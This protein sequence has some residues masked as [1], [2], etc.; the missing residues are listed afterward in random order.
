[1]CVGQ[2]RMGRRTKLSKNF[3]YS[4]ILRKETSVIFF[5]RFSE[6]LN[7][8]LI[9]Y[10]GTAEAQRIM[11]LLGEGTIKITSPETF[12]YSSDN[13]GDN[14]LELYNTCESVEDFYYKSLMVLK[15]RAELGET[16][17][18][19]RE[20]FLALCDL[21]ANR[22]KELTTMQLGIWIK[23]LVAT[24]V[25]AT[26]PSPYIMKLMDPRM[27]V[28]V[29]EQT[30]LNLK[31]YPTFLKTFIKAVNEIAKES[32]IL[33]SSLFF[34]KIEFIFPVYKDTRLHQELYVAS[35]FNI[36]I[37]HV[38]S[39]LRCVPSLTEDTPALR[40]ALEA[41]Q[42]E[43]NYKYIN[44]DGIILELQRIDKKEN[45][46][47]YP[48]M[49]DFS[50]PFK[51]A[52][53]PRAFML[54][55]RVA[56]T[57]VNYELYKRAFEPYF[58]NILINC[59]RLNEKSIEAHMDAAKNLSLLKC[60]FYKYTKN[61]KQKKYT[62]KITLTNVTEMNQEFVEFVK[63]KIEQ[64][65]S[66]TNMDFFA[67]I[68]YRNKEVTSR[69]DL[70]KITHIRVISDI[71]ADYN[72][73]QNYVFN[74]GDDFV[75]NCGDTGGD[76]RTCI[77]WHRNF[78]KHGVTV[79]GNHLGY[80]SSHPELNVGG[81][82]HVDNTKNTQI[83]ELG[84]TLMDID[85]VQF[86]SNSVAEYK[87]IIIIGST[88]Y[89]DFAL[90]GEQHIEEAMQ[91]ARL[92]MNDFKFPMVVG[93]REYSLTPEGWKIKMRK[94][95]E[96]TVRNFTPQDHAYYFHYSFNFIREKV[97]EYKHKPIVIVTHHA[98]SPYSISHEY[99][100]SML[101][102]AFAS[103]LNKYIV[104]HPE[105]RLWCHGHCHNISDYILGETRVVCC[106]FGYNNE[107][108]WE[109]PNKYGIRIALSDIR[110]RKKSWEEI[111]KEEIQWGLVKVYKS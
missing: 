41:L 102:P 3:N 53:I 30:G 54:D 15:K 95:E 23:N 88:L 66:S 111:C 60:Y 94:R 73:N 87:G 107:N 50:E 22:G 1:M 68:V 103:N 36:P 74:F 51:A 10:F 29:E 48:T 55:R 76:A 43:K 28:D 86:M 97:Q 105:I 99:E 45:F 11:G 35:T 98:P 18:E 90:Y 27:R 106:P 46:K 64:V 92:N 19:I 85:K 8:N 63:N 72:R 4:S 33:P 26:H 79:A 70:S 12:L 52:G 16:D 65:K 59:S 81:N 5:E 20:F 40:V 109:L 44:L 91:Y 69:V 75:I 93:H 71:H 57:C 89:T 62:F 56:R 6:K 101:N 67:E 31:Y 2:R 38:R 100:G 25:N 78:V 104:E 42:A 77:E 34:P 80:S 58:S 49:K 24:L 84:N 14:S 9:K 17:I 108:D 13:V 39:I 47:T 110:S 83:K 61:L 21:I 96:S 32:K 7:E 37:E 82:F